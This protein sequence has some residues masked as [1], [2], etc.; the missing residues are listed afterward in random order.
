MLAYCVSCT[1]FLEEYR[2]AQFICVIA[3]ARNGHTLATFHGKAEGIILRAPR[4][5]NGF[6]YDPLFYFAEIKK[7]FAELGAEEKAL[8]SHRGAAFRAFLEWVG[9][10]RESHPHVGLNRSVPRGTRKFLSTCMAF[11][12]PAVVALGAAFGLYFLPRYL[13]KT[14]LSLVIRSS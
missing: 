1:K 14:P 12:L 6:G 3:A 7:T 9:E 4:G 13:Q 8:Y 11:R 10:S 5:D 2:T